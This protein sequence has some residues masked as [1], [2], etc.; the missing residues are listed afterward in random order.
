L[1]NAAELARRLNEKDVPQVDRK[2]WDHFA[3]N[4][5]APKLP[6]DDNAG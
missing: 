1:T 5:T 4:G 2:I 6:L 3:T